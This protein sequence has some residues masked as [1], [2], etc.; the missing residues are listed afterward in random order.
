MATDGS[1]HFKELL[2]IE[3]FAF[4]NLYQNEGE[5]SEADAIQAR[6]ALEAPNF[7]TILM[8]P[9]KLWDLQFASAFH[10]TMSV[11]SK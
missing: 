11:L 4:L 3:W 8:C 10:D 6:R 7:P 2:G 1:T 9:S 5:R